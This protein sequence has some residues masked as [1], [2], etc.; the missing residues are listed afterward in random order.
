MVAARFMK[1]GRGCGWS[2]MD[3][4]FRTISVVAMGVGG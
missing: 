2:L 4:P 1:T 3:V